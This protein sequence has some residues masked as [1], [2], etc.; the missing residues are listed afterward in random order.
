MSKISSKLLGM[1]SCIMVLLVGVILTVSFFSFRSVT[2]KTIAGKCQTSVNFLRSSIEMQKE[3]TS[4]FAESF[5]A[6]NRLVAG[7]TDGDSSGIEAS[8]ASVLN[9]EGYYAAVSDAGGKAIWT[10]ENVVKSLDFSSALNGKAVSDLY[11]DG[12][13]LYM[14]ASCP[15]YSGGSV[16]GALII[17]YDLSNTALVDN[18][19]EQTGNEITVFIGDIR[20]NTTVL[21]DKG[22]RGVGTQLDPK[23]SSKVLKGETYTGK[24]VILKQ[25]MSVRYEP[26]TNS[27][28]EIL[29][30]LFSG[31]PT[32]ENDRLFRNVIF[33]LLGISIV[34]AIFALVVLAKV[35]QRIVAAPVLAIKDKMMAVKSG[36]LNIP[37]AAFKREKNE[38]SELADAVEDTVCTLEEYIND[39]SNV[40][41]CMANYDFSISSDVDY[42]GEFSAIKDALT[43]IKTN[44]RDIIASL[45]TASERIYADSADIS[46]GATVLAQGTTEQAAT[47]EEL[48]ASIATVS[49]NVSVN[50][51][52]ASSAAELSE[53]VVKLVNEEELAVNNMLDAITDI[54]EKSKQIS[55]VIK[56][57]EDIAFQTNILALNAAVEAARAGAAGKGFAVVA[58][59][60]RNLAVNSAEAAKSTSNL[61]EATIASV[62]G[63]T[64]H[65]R[66]VA[67]S[68]KEVKNISERSNDLMEEI[69]KATAEQASALSQIRTGME[70]IS[71][72]VQQNSL[73][74]EES[75]ASSQKLTDEFNQLQSI[76]LKF[77]I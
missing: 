53:N 72:V 39:I 67:E 2:D 42:I 33:L 10:S 71:V 27:S 41:S 23:I 64:M 9:K 28:G 15:V 24:A 21:N 58:E 69:N 44:I 56:A 7:I 19:K 66:S 1:A 36:R 25:K 38:T 37:M 4:S 73:T 26:L 63:G 49:E 50:A 45:Q 46:N 48:M 57:I 13:G 6:D 77:R 76:I 40:L 65:A 14:Q 32:A 74:A 12:N 52:N 62:S 20:L 60:V 22:E 61:I 70:Q 35:T 29:G 16:I 68:M 51:A 43:A 18:V 30:I 31:Q 3:E 17:G 59:E 8:L 54:E 47:I 11:S 34:I 75:S 55:K 5:S